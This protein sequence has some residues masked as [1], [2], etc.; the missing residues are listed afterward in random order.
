MTIV[1]VPSLISLLLSKAEEKGSPLT[2]EEVLVIR[3]NATAISVDAHTALS[4][5]E[6]RG[7]RDI[8]PEYC[9][10]EWLAFRS[11]H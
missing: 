10:A 6:S 11:D 4:M 8:D 3:D 5:S 1:F 2:E 9:W 7:Y